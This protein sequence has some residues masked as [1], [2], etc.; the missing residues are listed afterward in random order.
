MLVLLAACGGKSRNDSGSAVD[1][2]PEVVEDGALEPISD[3]PL[4]TDAPIVTWASWGE[5]FVI[6]ACR[7]CHSVNA[8]NRYGSPEDVNFDTRED[9]LVLSDRILARATGE[10]TTMPP[11]GGVLHADRAKLEIWLTCWE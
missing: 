2:D 9:V 11:Q 8:I 5:G 7:S 6:G 1:T 4:C 10:S 3:D